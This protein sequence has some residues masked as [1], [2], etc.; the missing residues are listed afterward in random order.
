MFSSP[1]WK[2]LE[3]VTFQISITTAEMGKVFFYELKTTF[4]HSGY[5]RTLKDAIFNIIIQ[6]SAVTICATIA[7]KDYL[8][9]TL[10]DSQTKIVSSF[11]LNSNQNA[12]SPIKY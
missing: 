7:A 10:L 5:V 2:V 3:F 1:N 8:L 12:T 4:Y 11:H 9:L 6:G